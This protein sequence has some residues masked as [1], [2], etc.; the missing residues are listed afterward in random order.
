MRHRLRLYTGD[1][2]MVTVAE[3]AV[4]VRLGDITDALADAVRCRRTW[5]SDFADEEI[6]IPPDLYDVLTTYWHLRPGA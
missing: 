6:Q 3:P 4:S 5:L 2:D 1:D